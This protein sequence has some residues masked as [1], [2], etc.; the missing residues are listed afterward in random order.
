MKPTD[1]AKYL[2][3]FLSAYLTTQKN[4]SKNTVHSYRDMFK[5]L[6]KYCQESKNIP[7]ERITLDLLSS[8]L[9]T[10]FL[11]W[12]ETER[13]C[14]I[15][16]RN[17][18]LAAIHSFFRYV[19]AEE[20]AGLFHFQKVIAIPLKKAKKTE[21][22]HLTPEAMKLLL[23]QPDRSCLKGRRNLTLMSVLYDT[24]ARVQELIDIKVGD[25]I[26]DAPSV[27]VLSGKGNKVRRVPL[28]K[29]TVALL[30]RYILEN[31]LDKSWKN[32]YHLFTN[33]QHN[34]LTREGVAYIISK[35]VALARQTSTLVPSK[36]KVHMLRHSKAMHLLQAGVNLIYIR[37]FL[38]HVDLKTT[39]IYA[40]TDTETKRKAIENAYP[41]MIDGNLPDWNKDQ[42]LLSW[43]SELK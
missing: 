19:Q 4:V 25:V 18:R 28:M 13:K 22:E 27:I 6:I 34:K 43:L 23:E 35:Y 31:K 42:A 11:E 30:E 38:G 24:G 15:S 39:E 9:L 32:E 41:D 10:D 3:D 33:N 36:V 26:L 16:T 29:N 40:R 2:T 37:D 7:A 8:K 17:Q 20:P 1:F 5:L 21:V 12:L 14:S